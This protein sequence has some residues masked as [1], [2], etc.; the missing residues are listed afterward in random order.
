[1]ARVLD[2]SLIALKAH[3]A[4]SPDAARYPG[5]SKL[6]YNQKGQI[7]NKQVR[8]PRTQSVKPEKPNAILDKKTEKLAPK[9]PKKDPNEAATEKNI[10]WYMRKRAVE[11]F[12]HMDD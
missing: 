9:I 1:M 7:L 11:R 8:L 12:D 5:Y 2:L 3:I 6:I 10:P 4:G